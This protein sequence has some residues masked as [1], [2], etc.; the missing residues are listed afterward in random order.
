MDAGR[1]EKYNLMN[2]KRVVTEENLKKTKKITFAMIALAIDLITLKWMKYFM[3]WFPSTHQLLSFKHF[4]AWEIINPI[5]ASCVMRAYQG[6]R[7]R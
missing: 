3:E 1:A 5:L 6:K 4:S 7:W 2:A